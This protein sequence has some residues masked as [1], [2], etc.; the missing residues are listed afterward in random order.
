MR[1]QPFSPLSLASVLDLGPTGNFYA[2]RK[3]EAEQAQLGQPT[4]KPQSLR[5]W[6]AIYASRR[7][8]NG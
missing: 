2:K 1:P 7:P 5:D 3:R 6:Q 8:A 4:P